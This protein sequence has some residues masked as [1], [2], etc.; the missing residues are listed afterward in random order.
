MAIILTVAFSI[1]IFNL[2]GKL[3]SYREREEV[4]KIELE[5]AN[6]RGDELSEYEKYTQTDEY[7]RN[8]ART[9]LGLVKENEVIFREK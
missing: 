4:L 2:F 9:K 6:A 8:T 7:I 5:A 1:Q 3:H